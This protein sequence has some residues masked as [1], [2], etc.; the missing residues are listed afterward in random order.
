[1]VCKYDRCDTVY[2]RSS[3]SPKPYEFGG[4]KPPIRASC[5]LLLADSFKLVWWFGQLRGSAG[6]LGRLYIY[7][8]IYRERELCIK[9]YKYDQIWLYSSTHTHTY[10]YIHIIYNIY[11]YILSVC[12]HQLCTRM[13]PHFLYPCLACGRGAILPT[14]TVN[15]QE[16]WG[17]TG[18]PLGDPEHIVL[19]H[20][21]GDWLLKNKIIR[22]PRPLPRQ[23]RRLGP[24]EVW[25]LA[26]SVKP[27][28][29][30]KHLF[31][32]PNPADQ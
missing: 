21:I 23:G 2:L 12:V 24:P 32:S 22:R 26:L 5:L 17:L 6:C 9:L 7:I 27:S 29:P 15:P 18:G 30:S 13:R 4:P 31:G 20:V 16:P 8:Y 19:G 10:I 28:K 25:N 14:A 1:M 3:R 11:I